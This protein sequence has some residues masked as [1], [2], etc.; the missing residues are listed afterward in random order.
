M[1]Q[2]SCL[3]LHSVAVIWF[4][5]IYSPW[6][7]TT[8]QSQ[9]EYL[10]NVNHSRAYAASIPPASCTYRAVPLRRA[11]EVPALTWSDTFMPTVNNGREQTTTTEPKNA[12]PLPMSKRSN[13]KTEQEKQCKSK[14]LDRVK[15]KTRIHFRASFQR[16]RSC[17][18]CM[19]SRAK[20]SLLLFCW[21]EP[22]LIWF[23]LF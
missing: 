3:W 13:K 15:E 7:N 4:A 23:I 1:V 11:G 22:C 5:R 6:L 2:D 9:G 20:Q 18:I 8:N 12:P 14:E 16:W 17:G 10:R 19:D 21:T